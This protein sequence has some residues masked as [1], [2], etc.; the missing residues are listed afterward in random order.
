MPVI[1][2]EELFMKTR[3]SALWGRLFGGLTA[4]K[5]LI[6]MLG[7]MISTFGIHNISAPTSPRAAS[8]G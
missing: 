5:L 3:I 1:F 7:A 6:I 2:K 8:S 4:S